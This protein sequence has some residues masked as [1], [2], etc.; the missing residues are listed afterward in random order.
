MVGIGR[1]TD[2]A[3][4]IVLHLASLES[5][6]RVT[7]GE[8]AR[9]RLIPPALIRRIVSRL[10]AAGILKTARGCGGG[11]ALA[12]SS[13]KVTLRDVVE[14][15]EGQVALNGCVVEP[16]D[17]PL[18]DLCPVQ[19]AWGRASRELA[20]SLARI[21]FSDLAASMTARSWVGQRAEKGHPPRTESKAGA[22]GA[23]KRVEGRRPPEGGAVR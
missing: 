20:R 1:Q 13:G 10:S 6:A 3:A 19:R 15:M 17:C 16:G 9:K 22:A 14:A 11:I 5:G 21:R 23:P 18:S 8:I 7:A 2:Y 4:R 12:R